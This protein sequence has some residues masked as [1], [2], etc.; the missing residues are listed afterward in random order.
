VPSIL[1]QIFE[2]KRVEL[3]EQ[4]ERVSLNEIRAAAFQAPSPRDF[5]AELRRHK[6]AI[7]AE[8]KRASPSKGDILPGLDPAVVAYDYQAAGAAAVSVLTD[9]HFKG[10]LADLTVVRSAVDLPILRK[11]FIFDPYQLYES[12]A[13]GSDCVLLIAAMLRSEQLQALAELARDLGLASLIEVHNRE[14]CRG[15]S[16]LGAALIG[17][18]NRDLHTFRTDLTTTSQLLAGYD[19]KAL[20]VSESGIETPEHIR[21]LYASGA[22]AF[23]IGE[24]LLRGGTPRDSL[25]TLVN[26]FDESNAGHFV[27]RP[28]AAEPLTPPMPTDKSQE[29]LARFVAGEGEGSE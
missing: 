2:A 14:E 19:G 27:K 10:S 3:A 16:E 28:A 12:R 18:N 23:L 29:P 22:R 6:P 24:S 4:R 15:A 11:D 25:R 1:D 17:I 13:A 26:C 7:I 8:V 21:Q 9:G 5:V 20:I